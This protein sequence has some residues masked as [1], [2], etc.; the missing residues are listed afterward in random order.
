M[1]YISIYRYITNNNISFI[2]IWETEKPL[3]IKGFMIFPWT[4]I[5]K[6]KDNSNF[7]NGGVK[8][9]KWPKILAFFPDWKEMLFF[10]G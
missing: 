9:K 2:F 8:A 3:C 6:E 5:L 10:N 4:I 7:Y 1:Y